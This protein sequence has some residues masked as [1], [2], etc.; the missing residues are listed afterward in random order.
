M[1]IF[2]DNQDYNDK[3]N[4]FL[5]GKYLITQ[6]DEVKD[7][8]FVIALKNFVTKDVKKFILFTENLH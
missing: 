5:F 3:L 6:A 2:N 7:F 1:V 8:F 4:E